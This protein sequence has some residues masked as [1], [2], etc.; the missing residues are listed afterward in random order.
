MTKYLVGCFI[1]LLLLSPAAFGEEGTAAWWAGGP[2]EMFDVPTLDLQR[3]YYGIFEKE[4][5][6]Q[7]VRVRTREAKPLVEP[8][9][10][11][12]PTFA[13]VEAAKVKAA[14]ETALEVSRKAET[15]ATEAK[16]NSEQAIASANQSIN[17]A[18]EA[19][20]KTNK[21]ID[22]VNEIN[23][24]LTQENA[25]LRFEMEQKDQSLSDEIANLNKLT[26]KEVKKAFSLYTVKKGD[27]LIKIAE[28][29]DIYGEGGAWKALYQA[30]RDKI[31]DPNLIYPGQELKVPGPEEAAVLKAK[32]IKQKP[33]KKPVA[34]S[35][36]PEKAAPEKPVLQ[37]PKK[38]AATGGKPLVPAPIRK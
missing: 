32:P 27:F 14:A 12:V 6:S 25:K 4:P 8:V 15:T 20:D 3:S 31:K 28:K 16:A 11:E 26:A 1:S 5:G 21:A 13:E 18:N 24:K 33:V 10:K 37:I 36:T 34:A 17:T 19:I 2:S 38:T 9:I 29:K 7:P 30:N 22:Q 35:E 23:E